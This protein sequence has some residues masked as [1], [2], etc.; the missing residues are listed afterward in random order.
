MP[1]KEA[2]YK[3]Q[4]LCVT[5][6]RKTMINNLEPAAC[7]LLIAEPFMLDPEF[8][9]AVILITEYGEQ[10]VVGFVL[11]QTS[12]LLINDAVI[13]F[14]EVEAQL[15]T[16][17]PCNNE[18]LHF[19][20]RCPNK[21][22][23]GIAI[24]NGIFWGGDFEAVKTM[25]QLNL[26]TTNEIKFFLGYSGWTVGQLENELSMNSWIVSDQYDNN[27][28]FNDEEENL[29]KK[30]VKNLGGRYAHIVNFPS[31]PQLN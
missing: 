15:F 16:G 18:R 30:A 1:I 12:G 28:I 10:G 29:W 4:Q 21:I 31:N 13:D 7:R 23:E 24:G 5:S 3:I 27:L 20:H 6:K 19:L 26:I 8:K 25:F 11:N 17:G 2:Y 22:P 9:R 14:P